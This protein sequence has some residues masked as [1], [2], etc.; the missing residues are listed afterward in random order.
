MKSILLNLCKSGIFLTLA[1]LLPF[2]GFNQIT[3]YPYANDF[4]SWT[5]NSAAYNCTA[6]GTITLSDSWTNITGDD[7][8]WNVYSGPTASSSTGPSS[9][10][11]GSGNYLYVEASSCYSKTGS[12]TMPDLDLSVVS[13]PQLIFHY[14]MYGTTMGS[15]S[16]EVSTNN[17]SSWSSSIWSKSGDQGNSWIEATVSLAAYTSFADLRIRFTATTSTNWDG[18]IAIDEVHVEPI[19]PSNQQESNVTQSGASLSWTENGTATSWDIEYGVNGFT[20]GAGTTVTGVT[21][22]P[23]SISG[24]TVSTSY[25]W[26][27]RANYSSTIKSCYTGPST[28]TTSC[29]TQTAAYTQDFD[30]LTPNNG[31]VVC[32]TTYDITSICWDNDVTSDNKYWVARSAASASVTTGPT[33]D[34]SGTGNYVFLEASSCYSKTANLHSPTINFLSLNNP[35]L[36]FY[37]HMYG[38]TMGSLNIYYSTDNG[39]NWSS[40]IWS[41]SGDQGNSWQ[42]AFIDIS[43]ISSQTAVIFRL[44][45]I[46][47]TSYSSDISIDGF[48]V[49]EAINCYY[50]S[51]QSVSSISNT[52]AQL[53][54]TAGSS[55]TLWDIE[56]GA[57]GF[58]ATGTPNISS[59][60]SN[61]YTLSSLTAGTQYDWYI[62]ANCGS[63]NYSN[64]IGP[65][66][67]ST[68]CTAPTA[69]TLPF[70]EDWES[71]NGITFNAGLICCNSTYQWNFEN[72]AAEGRASWGTDSY[73]SN[74]GSGGITLD[75]SP[76]GSIIVNAAIL[77]INLSNYTSSSSLYLS[78]DWTDHSDEEHSGDKVWIRGNSS[79]SWIEAY[80]IDPVSF[81]NGT[82][83]IVSGI[84]IDALLTAASQTVSSTFQVKLG[85][86]DNFPVGTDGITYDN[87]KIE[88]SGCSAP[89]SQ[90]TSSI[91]TTSVILGWTESGSSTTWDIEYGV[92]GY[93]QGTGTTVNVSTNPYTLTGLNTGGHYDWYI[94]ANCGASN[95][96]W[97]GPNIFTTNCGSLTA[98]TLP[99]TEGFEGGN[100][101]IKNDA[102]LY[103][104]PGYQWD[105]TTT[106]DNGRVSYGSFAEQTN[107][108][109]GAITLDVDASGTDN[110]NHLDLT[111]NLSNYTS[112]TNLEFAFSYVDHG[113]E[114]NSDNKIY[115]RGSSSDLWVE[116]YDL[117]PASQTDNVYTDVTSIDIDSEL[118][119]ATPSQTVSSS[120]QIRFSQEDDH[121]VPDDGISFDDLSVSLV[122]CSQPTNLSAANITTT[123]AD[124][125]WT[126]SGSSWDIEIGAEGFTPSG[127]ADASTSSNPYTYTGLTA[128]TSYDFYVRN[129]CGSSTYSS[130]TGPYTFETSAIVS[131][132]IAIK[133]TY[134][135]PTYSRLN[136][137]GSSTSPELY[138]YDKFSFT[139]PTTGNYTI[140][141]EY[142]YDG[143]VHLYQ[144]SFNA[145]SPTTNWLCGND[146]YEGIAK[147]QLADVSLTSGTTYILVHSSWDTYEYGNFGTGTTTIE[148]VGSATVPSTGDIYGD[149]IG[150]AGEISSTD[151][152]QRT[153]TYECDDD[154]GWT[155]FYDNNSS[156][157][158][159]G[160][161]IIILSIK[162]N[163]NDIGNIGDAG[164]AVYI[165]G[166]NGAAHV[167]ETG[168]NYVTTFHGWWVFN[169]YWKVT[170]NDEPSTDVSV[171]FYYTQDDFDDVA[172]AISN[173]AG[174][175]PSAHTDMLFYKINSV[176]G[177]YDVD[178][179]QG[180][181]SVPESATYSGD[182]YWGYTHGTASTSNWNHGTYDGEHFGEYIVGRFSGGGGGISG[183]NGGDPLSI[184]L[185]EFYGNVLENTNELI[186]TTS[187]EIN[188]DYFIIE[189]SET[190]DGEYKQIGKIKASGNSNQLKQ[191]RFI[192]S[193]PYSTSYYRLKAFDYQ[194]NFSTSNILTLKRKSTTLSIVNIFPIPSSDIVYLSYESP[195]NSPINLS[196]IDN[197]GQKIYSS[198]FETNMGSNLVKLDLSTIAPGVYM[199]E[200]FQDKRK[201]SHKLIIN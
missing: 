151:G 115:I 65:I 154:L 192:D 171:R 47:G 54:W 23:Y 99:Y 18:D 77:T 106:L 189:S 3:T 4:D 72:S 69:A 186:W 103:C 141:T 187:S 44:Q 83:N 5:T 29:G 181:T 41:I 20:Q 85:Q 38:S 159:Y 174:T 111:M 48:S 86:E 76:S 73:S 40:A 182:G 131:S 155:H 57:A 27:V 31:S 68:T 97:V 43:S 179:S 66:Q 26:Y 150:V 50:P 9:G 42:Q 56:Y 152:T 158:D 82:F 24:L 60:S 119:G 35:E 49:A 100:G 130:W 45:G 127:T 89:S 39:S 116:V 34:Q 25:D 95:S 102:L 112:S 148:G 84:D 80:D 78:F 109:S 139:V 191:Y 176:T 164:F 67:F 134:C 61:P 15:L 62:R 81:T 37:Y 7:F 121:S 126:N 162:K 140:T 132:S 194:A 94:R 184:E 196:L 157:D 144:T 16:V 96:L 122:A 193:N 36:S 70:I 199:I 143:Y 88:E 118:S 166:D 53:S 135:S 175:P 120:F 133:T 165:D 12:I 101:Y 28:F 185:M 104:G 167:I 52:S 58:T 169:R 87:I 160:D 145:S 129:D 190:I 170:T 59:V 178:P 30:G 79:A 90:T 123:S 63:G 180:H 128:N 168:T 161:D 19:A 172:T 177:T 55:E 163:S 32:A 74:G 71:S 200:L 1:M 146:D 183:F 17:G 11:G 195:N 91:T 138:F 149:A 173:D 46:T 105:L 93:T 2:F 8:D 22:N 198:I 113:N 197:T 201:T 124:L 156:S 188:S 98:I 153:A 147:S 114:N 125:G 136:E 142:N 107:T 110:V 64:W 108:G 75:R 21:T 13:N 6:D 51:N 137:I 14:H 33:S 117:L 10:Y 92:H